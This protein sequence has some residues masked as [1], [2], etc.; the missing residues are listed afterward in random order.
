MRNPYSAAALQRC[1][2]GSDSRDFNINLGEDRTEILEAALSASAEEPSRIADPETTT[3]G[4]RRCYFYRDYNAHLIVRATARYLSQRFR[5]A[6]PNRDRVVQAVIEGMCEGAPFHV[7]RRDIRSFYENIPIEDLR[8][9]LLFDTALPKQLRRHLDA[10]FSI[11]TAASKGLPRGI[12]LTTILAELAMHEFDQSVRAIPGVYRY[13][14]YSDDILVFCTGDLEQVEKQIRASLPT[15]MAFNQAKCSSASFDPKNTKPTEWFDYLGYRFKAA[16]ALPKKGRPRV[17][18]VSIAPI[19]INKLKTR[20]VLSLRG[21][22]GNKHNMLL[23]RMRYLSGN[24]RVRRLP[25]YFDTGRRFTRSG[26]YF[27]YKR[28]GSYTGPTRTPTPR[29]ELMALD[30]YYHRLLFSTKSPFSAMIASN[31]PPATLARLKAISF[32][33]GY[34]EKIFARVPR[35]VAGDV[36][37]AWRGF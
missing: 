28:C 36:K 30:W 27:N 31:V 3:V 5:I 17:C 8:H 26:I 15:D 1:V 12:G 22:D 24:Y 13:F 23:Y 37:M 2:R 35:G 21:Y 4:G 32:H 25:G 16:T 33:M 18:D 29:I 10:Y 9:R 19:K 20:I 34:A 14:R 6:A 7:I 11:R